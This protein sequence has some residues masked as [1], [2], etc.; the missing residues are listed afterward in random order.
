MGGRVD[1]AGTDV[2]TEDSQ[3]VEGLFQRSL[4][5]ERLG[6][7]FRINKLY[8][9]EETIGCV[10]GRVLETVVIAERTV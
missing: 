4:M 5:E 10:M 9:F 7:G 6:W 3:L 8:I 1:K 2:G